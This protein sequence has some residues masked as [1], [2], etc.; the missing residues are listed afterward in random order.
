MSLTQ[1]VN[2]SLNHVRLQVCTIL[3]T[4]GV[5]LHH[6]QA[7]AY[8]NALT[9]DKANDTALLVEFIDRLIQ[10]LTI[11]VLLSKGLHR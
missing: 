2:K 6:D 1:F 10:H 11:L 8:T 4:V 9:D 5:A 7:S 3:L